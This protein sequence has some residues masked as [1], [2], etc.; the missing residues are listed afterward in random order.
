MRELERI[1]RVLNLIEQIWSKYPDTR[2]NQLIDNL[3]WQY[4]NTVNS[5]YSRVD[6]DVQY[7][8]K[9]NKKYTEITETK[10]PDL[11]YLEDNEFENFLVSYISTLQ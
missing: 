3:Q 2:F 9:G 10:I 5:K 8:E 4:I 11:F 1:K 7:F 6:Y